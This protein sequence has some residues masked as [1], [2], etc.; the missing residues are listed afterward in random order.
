MESHMSEVIL[1][2]QQAGLVPVV[3]LDTPEQA[4]PLAKALLDGGSHLSHG[5]S[6][7]GYQPHRP[8]SP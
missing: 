7:A 8:G 3:V 1:K 4:V 2:F 5:C 6:R